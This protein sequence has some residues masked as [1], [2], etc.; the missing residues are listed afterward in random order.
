L[1]KE[2]AMPTLNEL[3][4]QQLAGQVKA[5]SD[6]AA[7]GPDVQ[8]RGIGT[9]APGAVNVPFGYVNADVMAR[10]APPAPIGVAPAAPAMSPVIAPPAAAPPASLDIWNGNQ[11]SRTPYP[12]SSTAALA[13]AATPFMSSG[14]PGTFGPSVTNGPP[15]P[16]ASGAAGG[17]AGGSGS[18]MDLINRLADQ[19][20]RAVGDVGGGYAANR[21]ARAQARLGVYQN[22]HGILAAHAAQQTADIAR[23]QGRWTNSPQAQQE[24]SVQNLAGLLLNRNPN[25]TPGDA[26]LQARDTIGHGS[27]GGNQSPGTA[28]APVT[29]G[30]EMG[31]QAPPRTGG[32]GQITPEQRENLRV[33]GLINSAAYINSPVQPGQTSPPQT[34]RPVHSF[35]SNILSDVRQNPQHLAM[36]IDF[37]R[38]NYGASGVAGPGSQSFNQWI[39]STIPSE[40]TPEYTEQESPRLQLHQALQSLLPIPQGGPETRYPFGRAIGLTSGNSAYN[41]SQGRRLASLFPG[42][43]YAYNGMFG[44]TAGYYRSLMNSGDII[45]QLNAVRMN[46]LQGR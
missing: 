19:A 21:E 9:F 38:R 14:G 29:P 32:G 28:N 27:S 7:A 16:G 26:F 46:P 17:S 43:E 42:G 45:S 22:A 35:F 15:L 30:V 8:A 1:F 3:L 4:Q 25:M 40:N 18:G 31:P 34:L 13:E 41:I 37:A 36:A 44:P 6:D 23:E 12:G 10:G 39:N 24:R 11:L 33:Q 20:E 5:A 2:Y